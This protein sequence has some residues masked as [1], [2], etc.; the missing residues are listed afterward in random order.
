MWEHSVDDPSGLYSRVVSRT[1]YYLLLNVG[2]TNYDSTNIT[3]DDNSLFLCSLVI[4][5]DREYIQSPVVGV[6]ET[7][8][9]RSTNFICIF[10]IV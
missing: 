1:D 6:G 7:W 4:P 10:I 3:N 5:L 8:G 9:Q 2:D